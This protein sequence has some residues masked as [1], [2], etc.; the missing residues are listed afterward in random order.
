MK[1]LSYDKPEPTL[2]LK[3]EPF[4]EVKPTESF[5]VNLPRETDLVAEYRAGEPTRE[6]SLIFVVSGGE[7]RERQYLLELTRSPNNSYKKCVNVV[8]TSAAYDSSRHRGSSP[9]DILEYWGSIFDEDSKM[10]KT[11][12]WEGTLEENDSVYFLTD[13]DHFRKS[14]EKILSLPS[15]ATPPPYQWI[16]SNPCFEIWLYYSYIDDNP[17]DKLGELIPLEEYK[18]PQTLK[19][20]CGKLHSGGMNPKKAFNNIDR[21][22]ENAERY[23]AYDNNSIP[24]L[25]STDMAIFAKRVWEY[26]HIEFQKQKESSER[27]Q[28]FKKNLNQ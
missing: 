20:L 5:C 14:L 24:Q 22:I 28:R 15:Q 11:E 1:E 25:F 10:L 21:A 6:T 2:E 19:T 26:I 4:D 12:E 3:D 7:K 17:E 16:I 27:S 8:F 13:L 23:R 18:R 9:D